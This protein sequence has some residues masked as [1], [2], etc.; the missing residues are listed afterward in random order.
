MKFK[1]SEYSLFL[2][3]KQ[4]YSDLIVKFDY[5]LRPNH[6]LFSAFNE[7]CTISNKSNQLK[8]NKP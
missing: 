6:E 3:E 4:E 5:L 2:R 8:L 7:K 1:F